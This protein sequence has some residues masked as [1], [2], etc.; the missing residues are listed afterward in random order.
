[1]K[2][3]ESCEMSNKMVFVPYVKKTWSETYI[4][5][6]DLRA[7]IWLSDLLW[8]IKFSQV[9]KSKPVFFS[10]CVVP[11][12]KHRKGV[13]GPGTRANLIAQPSI[14]LN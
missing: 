10:F 5:E 2:L 1:M 11:G 9:V 7:L 13:P 4:F 8:K 14:V 6:T 3:G 12:Q